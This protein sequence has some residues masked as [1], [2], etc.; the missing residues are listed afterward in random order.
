[1][2]QYSVCLL[3]AMGFSLLS[4]EEALASVE[5]FW[6]DGHGSSIKAAFQSKSLLACAFSINVYI[7]YIQLS[8]LE[9]AEI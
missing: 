6:G 7:S 3:C 4:Q 9:L 2:Y 1:M 8:I 5:D